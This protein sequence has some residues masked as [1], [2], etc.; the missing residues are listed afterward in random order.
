MNANCSLFNWLLNGKNNFGSEGVF[1]TYVGVTHGDG[2]YKALSMRTRHLLAL[3][4]GN[5]LD[6]N[7]TACINSDHNEV[8]QLFD[9]Y[10]ID[11]IKLIY[12]NSFKTDF[13]LLLDG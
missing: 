4:N 3:V 12:I 1:P 6:L 13:S 11:F 8:L 2:S 10:F 5:K 9:F 7:K